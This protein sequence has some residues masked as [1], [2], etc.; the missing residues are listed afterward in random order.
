MPAKKVT[1]VDPLARQ[2]PYQQEAFW[3][4]AGIL[5]WIWRRQA[6]KSR[7]LGDVMLDW[8]MADAGVTVI[9]ASAA[10]RL[11]VENVRKAWE[12]W[13]ALTESYRALAAGKKLLLTTTADDDSG[14]LPDPDVL[15][16]MFE[17]QKLEVRLWHS[18]STY[19]R[20]LCVAPNP[21]TAVGWTGHVILD[22]VGR[23]PNFR[24]VW[25]A[26]EPIVSSN[27]QFKYRLSTTPPPDDTH[28]SYEL[29]APE[30][31]AVF[32]PNA[33][34]NYYTS[35]SG[36][37]VHRVDAWDAN[38]ANVPLYDLHTRQPLTPE[39]SRSRALDKTAWDRNYGCH[40]IRG[41]TAAI[42][43]FDLLNAMHA[44]QEAGCHG[45]LCTDQLEP[46]AL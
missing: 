45:I 26:M 34:G 22:E 13:S 8:M 3:N 32:I 15:L 9:I 28:Y 39:E 23:I 38:L 31:G 19:S 7:G 25:E 24:E 16:E 36:L 6:G 1:I 11:G 4:Q 20:A 14:R 2:R 18:R 30:P 21:D 41:G 40:F 10:L 35:Q 12:A 42:S 5:G 43:L 29:L 17:A 37:Q 27:P 46:A 44:G 33:R